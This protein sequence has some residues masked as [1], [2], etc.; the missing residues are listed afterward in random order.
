[1]VLEECKIVI[2]EKIYSYKYYCPCWYASDEETL[3]E[4]IQI[5]KN[6]EKENSDE[7]NCNEEN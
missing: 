7:E 1:M 2:K 5:E 3:L 6:S 4:K